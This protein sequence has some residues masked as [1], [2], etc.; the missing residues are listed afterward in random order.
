[1]TTNIKT[2]VEIIAISCAYLLKL[3]VLFLH[4][5]RGVDTTGRLY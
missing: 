2:V 4:I 3:L 5:I 1:M